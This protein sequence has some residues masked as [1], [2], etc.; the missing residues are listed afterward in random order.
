M[1]D[2][3]LRYQSEIESGVEKVCEEKLI[4]FKGGWSRH[5]VTYV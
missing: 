2:M 3:S 1:F 5:L 4:R